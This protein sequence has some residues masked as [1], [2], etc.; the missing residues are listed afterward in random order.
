MNIAYM[1]LGGCLG[2]VALN[3][4]Y[5]FREWRHFSA[6]FHNETYGQWWRLDLF[7]RYW[8]LELRRSTRKLGEDK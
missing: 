2:L 1:V 5:M 7:A 8:Y 3:M 6:T 4:Y